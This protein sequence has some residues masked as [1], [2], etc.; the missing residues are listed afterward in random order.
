MSHQRWNVLP[1]PPETIR[2]DKAGIS[3]VLGQILYHRGITEASQIQ[4]FLAGDVSLCSDPFLLPG[5]HQA[6]IRI[7]RASLTGEK[8]AIFGDFDTDGVT[9]T[10]LMVEGLSFLGIQATPYIPHRITEGYGLKSAALEN[11]HKQGVTLVISVDC[12]VTA[13]LPVKKARRLGMDIIVTDHHVPLDEI[14]LA[15]AVIDPKLPGS[16]YPFHELSGVGVALKLL[17]ALFQSMGK[18]LNTSRLFD[19]VA[20]GTVADMVPLLG[21]NRY[22]VIQ[23]LKVLN[24]NPRPG[25]QELMIVAGNRDTGIDS[26]TISWLL[27]PRLNAAGRLD[28][29]ISSYQLLTTV[30]TEEARSL[31]VH[32]HKKNLE[33]QELTTKA[34][35]L[36]KEQV[37]A[38]GLNAVILAQ[39]IEFPIGIC[40]LVASRLVDEYYRPALVVRTG[41]EFCTGSCRSIPEYNIIAALNEFQSTVGGLLHFGGHA[42]AAGFTIPIRKLARFGEFLSRMAEEQLKGLDLRP[43]ID[44]DAEVKFSELGGDVYPTIQKLSPFG[45]GN[46]VPSFLSR[47]VEVVDS[48]TMGSNAEHL[49][50][51]LKQ[52]GVVWNAVGFGLGKLQHEMKSRID[53]VYNIELDHWN[54]SRNL[55]LNVIDF[56][57]EKVGSIG[58]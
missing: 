2:F 45:Q 10:A 36:A 57:Q 51:K 50:L 35:S 8:I 17:Q 5:M 7:L 13:I 12:G 37:A 6:V 29:A 21:E 46:P 26:E 42:Q 23:G 52:G 38:S 11:L 41:E 15:S 24:D 49:K 44:I 31:A 33:R 55:R 56:Q 32:L 4:T 34:T 20:L 1:L 14:P 9:A 3:P 43:S 47:G 40:G 58:N 25:I 19:L 48:R 22:L 53:I 30:S 18:E 39:D 16:M 27:A 54:G 28:H